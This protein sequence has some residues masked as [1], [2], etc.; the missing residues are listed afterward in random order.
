M[1]LLASAFILAIGIVPAA[2]QS[3]TEVNGK[4]DTLFGSHTPYQ[5]FFDRLKKAI[6]SD[7]RAAV[8]AMVDYPFHARIRG[9]AL[10]IKDASQFIADY[11]QI[12]TGKVKTAVAKQTYATLFAN[13]QGIMIGDGEVWFSGICGDDS[14]KQQTIKVIAINN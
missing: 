9:K 1:F 10:K 8:A 6:G 2:A 12:M 4:L 14:C 5:T 3:A 13:A 7:D 11:D